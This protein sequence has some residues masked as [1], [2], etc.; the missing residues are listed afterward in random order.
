MLCLASR[1]LRC[2]IAGPAHRWQQMASSTALPALPVPVTTALDL[3]LFDT[4]LTVV[5]LRVE[6]KSL[7]ALNKRLGR[8]LFKR[9]GVRPVQSDPMS[10]AH[11]LVMLKP[12]VGGAALGALSEADRAFVLVDHGATVV[13][14]VYPLGYDNLNAD[15]ALRRVLPEGVE[16]PSSFETVGQ[17]AHMNLRAE[18]MP[19]RLLIGRVILDKNP[20]IRTI[21][22]KV[23]T[24]TNEFRTFA[25]EVI[26]GPDDL[27]VEVKEHGARPSGHKLSHSDN[28][29]GFPPTYE[30]L[31]EETP[32]A[33]CDGAEE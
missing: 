5:A 33:G 3:T 8:W 17:I 21:V 4:A 19:H 29:L 24:I 7:N 23:G 22:T 18:H 31:K 9:K 2:L 28:C 32:G 10:P 15:E 20:A 11:K 25:M 30:V 1:S 14:H 12:E 27:N 26:A 16:P 13:Q 6:S